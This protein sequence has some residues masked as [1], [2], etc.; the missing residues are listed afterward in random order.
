QEHT[1]DFPILSR[2][3]RDV[4]A[5]P[6]VSIAV[7]RL[8]SSCRHTLSDSRSSLSADS[9]SKTVITKEWLKRGFGDDVNYLEHISI[10]Q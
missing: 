4:L 8:F 2:I 1:A 10:H 6:G 9:A 7:E 3:A 5:I